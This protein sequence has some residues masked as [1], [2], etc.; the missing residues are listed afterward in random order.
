MAADDVVAGLDGVE[1]VDGVEAADGHEQEEPAEAGQEDGAGAGAGAG[2]AGR[3]F[4]VAV[5]RGGERVAGIMRPHSNYK[6]DG[7]GRGGRGR[8][9]FFWEDALRG[10]ILPSGNSFPMERRAAGEARMGKVAAALEG[11]SPRCAR[12]RFL[13][14]AATGAWPETLVRVQRDSPVGFRSGAS[15]PGRAGF[16]S[17]NLKER[18]PI[19]GVFSRDQSLP[20]HGSRSMSTRLNSRNS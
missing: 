10:D 8:R 1:N 18:T 6:T 20:R 15:L 7:E 17:R 13:A 19:G 14:S 12:A 11:P 3:W 9:A 16:P 2:E 5:R 4:H